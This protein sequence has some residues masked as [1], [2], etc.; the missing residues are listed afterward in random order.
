M[1]NITF[2]GGINEIGG[3]KFLVE[4]KGTRIFLDFGMQMGKAN[5]FYSEFLQPRVFN[6][7]GDLFEFGLL[8]KLDGVYRKDYSRHMGV[9]DYKK[10]T[11]VN[12][13]LLTHAHVD[14]AAYI[15]YL[16]PE[17]PI[18]CTDA[19]KLIMQA[20]QDTGSHEE[21]V[22]YKENFRVYENTKG[23][24]S[25]AKDDKNRQVIQR[26]IQTLTPYKKFNIDSIEVE[27]IPVDH[28]LPGVCGFVLHTSRGSVAYTADLRF[29]GRRKQESETFVEK[30]A[31]SDVDHILCEG[32][33]VEYNSSPTE[34]DVEK[35]VKDIVN[36]TKKLVVVSYPTRDLDRLLSFYLAAK[37]T[38]RT[39][40]IDLKQAYLLKLFEQSEK[41]KGTYPSPDDSMIRIYVPRK[42]WGLIDK[43]KEYW[44]D[45]QILNDYDV[46][47]RQ[48]ISRA[49]SV[50]YRDVSSK[51]QEYMFYCSDY[52]LQELIDVRPQEGSSYIR[53]STEPFDDEMRFDHERIK[54]WL[55]HFGLL[56][57]DDNWN[58][59][60][61]SGHGSKDQI[62]YV[63]QETKA[64]NVIPIHTTRED[65]FKQWHQSVKTV[66]INESITL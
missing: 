36:S 29:H 5:N 38:N 53:S 47:E 50:D 59:T 33:R 64:K 52:R 28:S 42:S 10:E 12:A 34:F 56:R 48:F 41:Y 58:V 51:Q 7:M 4:D 46:W 45:K 23:E 61:V 31:S 22:T 37:Q 16:R 62:R 43:A 63:V 18:Y 14:H 65:Y 44:T 49:N 1:T 27:P 20:L 32:T 13:V 15:H 26:E 8:P 35:D 6:G 57:K 21:Y 55:V 66:T 30:C 2:Y 40:V 60:H 24:I 25:R 39:L 9:D 54:R 11:S 17:I 19:T 3:N